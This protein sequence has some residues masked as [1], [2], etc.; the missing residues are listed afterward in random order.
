MALGLG[1]HSVTRLILAYI[2]VCV[3]MC[4]RHTERLEISS[5]TDESQL[6]LCYMC[7]HEM[8]PQSGSPVDGSLHFNIDQ[9]SFLLEGDA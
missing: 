2:R 9:K 3:F 4:V 1:L 5:I 6:S 7:M 8:N